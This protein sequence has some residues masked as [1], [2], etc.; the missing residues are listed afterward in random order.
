MNQ[1]SPKSPSSPNNCQESEKSRK[2]DRQLRLWG[3]NGQNRIESAHVC[4]INATAAGTEILKSLV[5]AGVGSFT[6]IDDVIVS[7]EDAN[8]FFLNSDSLGKNRAKECCSFLIEM[9]PDVRGDYIEDSLDN[10]LESNPDLFANFSVVCAA[11]IFNEKTLIKLSKILWRLN[12]PF[13]LCCTIGFVGY[14][15]FQVAEHTIIESHPDNVL[16]DLR[17]DA[18]FPGML[19][20]P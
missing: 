2:Y 4:L 17:L 7:S 8:N 9:N 15:R 12:V 1:K 13:L 19:A 20:F 16:E 14:L 5:L 3:D 11:N 10:I 18:P 6:I